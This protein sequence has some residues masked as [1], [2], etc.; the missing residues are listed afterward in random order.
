MFRAW[1]AEIDGLMAKQ[2]QELEAVLAGRQP[3][4]PSSRELRV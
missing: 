3:T 1:P 2:R 4:G